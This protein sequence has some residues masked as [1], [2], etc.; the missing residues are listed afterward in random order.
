MLAIEPI[1]RE[2][3]P[4]IAEYLERF[5]QTHSTGPENESGD[6]N[7]ARE[8]DRDRV[9]QR[10]SRLNWRLLENPWRRSSDSLGHILCDGERIA[11]C[12][13]SHPFDFG[14]KE[15]DSQKLRVGF[16]S[17]FFVDDEARGNGLLLFRSFLSDK[18]FD[19]HAVTTANANSAKLWES[20]RGARVAEANMEYL[21]PLK[22]SQLLE[23]I[24]IRRGLNR[25]LGPLLKL[26]GPLLDFAM[27]PLRPRTASLDTV[28]DWTEIS[29]VSQSKETPNGSSW[30]MP[31]RDTNY[32]EWAYGSSA[33]A[34]SPGRKLWRH[35]SRAGVQTW[36]GIEPQRIGSDKQV[37]V[38]RV[39]DV[40]ESDPID[41]PELLSVLASAAGDVDAI[42]MT[43]RPDRRLSG[44]ALLRTREFAH[45][46]TYIRSKKV[47]AKRL[48]KDLVIA[49]ADRI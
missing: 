31:I 25:S 41:D 45:S 10:L 48:A 38:A 21:L 6:S 14:W 40:V 2:K 18:S 46:T 42:V 35:T 24:L 3:L 29:E 16:S 11:G 20:M 36:V 1:T 8:L 23:E 28:T 37:R 13:L 33:M 19:V 43:G 44:S 7:H 47:D 32:F 39:L 49:D 17:D 30:A 27:R 12:H 15:T 34:S 22:A 9:A 26:G 5:S 4:R